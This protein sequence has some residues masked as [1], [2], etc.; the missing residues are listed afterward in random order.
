MRVFTFYRGLKVALLP[1]FV[2]PPDEQ[3]VE[4][5]LRLPILR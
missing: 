4:K 2:Q 1:E 5:L 3:A